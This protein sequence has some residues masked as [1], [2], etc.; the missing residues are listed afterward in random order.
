MLFEQTIGGNVLFPQVRYCVCERSLSYFSSACL[1]MTLTF[2]I[3]KQRRRFVSTTLS[4]ALQSS[5]KSSCCRRFESA[6]CLHL[7]WYSTTRSKIRKPSKQVS[8]VHLLPVLPPSNQGLKPHP[9]FLI[10]SFAYK[11]S[12][13]P[14][15]GS[16]FILDR[17]HY[18][19]V[20][21]KCQ[22]TLTQRHG[23]TPHD[24]KRQI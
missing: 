18:T 10:V 11:I 14:R 8:Q 13:K 9:P 12:S 23:V 21:S 22:D 1:R 3:I 4:I 19:H 2:V 16:A 6:Q 17:R 7:W 5:E 24:L 20:P 15:T